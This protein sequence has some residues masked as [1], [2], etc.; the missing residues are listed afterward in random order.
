MKPILRSHSNVR[1]ADPPT[2]D[3][4]L[5]REVVHMIADWEVSEE[6]ASEFAVRLLQYFRERRD[7]LLQTR[8]HF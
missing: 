2:N 1:Q 8:S 4:E 6:L 3:D 5:V 7:K